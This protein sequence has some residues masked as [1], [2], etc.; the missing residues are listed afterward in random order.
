MN[1][2]VLVKQSLTYPTIKSLMIE[3]EH[4]GID[5]PMEILDRGTE[6]LDSYAMRGF[7][8]R[9]EYLEAMCAA[10]L[11]ATDID[12]ADVVLVEER[13]P[14]TAETVKVV[15]YF[16]RKDDIDDNIVHDTEAVRGS[17]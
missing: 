13:P 15:W 8:I 17:V 7:E 9:A 10:Y 1:D 5:R 6:I 16:A 2:P 11:M 12:P 3:A 14:F 4:L